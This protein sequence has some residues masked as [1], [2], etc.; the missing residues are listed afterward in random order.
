MVPGV[1][2]MLDDAIREHLELKRRRG[3][4]PG[5]IARE[6]QEAL[7]PVF[8]DEPGPDSLAEE[9]AL[10]GLPGELTVPG[11]EVPPTDPHLPEAAEQAAVQETAEIDME[12][13]LD[14]DAAATEQAPDQE[15]M[16]FE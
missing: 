1:M 9:A 4:D 14:E 8:P 11:E 12:R 15:R 13:V 6:E 5:E 3:A 2:G 7:D 16:S 10:E